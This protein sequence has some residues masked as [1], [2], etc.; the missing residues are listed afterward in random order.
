MVWILLSA[1]VL[2]L[3]TALAL[4]AAR[5]AAK[6]HLRHT[7]AERDKARTTG[8]HQARLQHPHIDLSRCIGCGTCVAACPEEGVLELVHGQAVVVHGARCV[9]H[10]RCA[11]ECPVGAIALTLGDVSD[12]RDL[13]VLRENLESPH[14]PGLFLAGEVT[15][16]A[17]VRTAITQGTAAADQ[18]ARRSRLHA[19][20]AIRRHVQGQAGGG[21]AVAE[22]PEDSRVIDLVI[23][24]AGP[25]GIA[26]SL[27][28]KEL[29][30]AFTTLEQDELGGTV[31]KYPRRK[32]VMTQPVELPLVGRLSRTSYSKE[33]LIEMWQRVARQHELPIQHGQ[34]F[35]RVERL[36]D[37]TLRVHTQTGHVDARSVVLALGRRGTP[38]RLGIPGEELPKVA[39]SLLD[40]HSYQGRRI[41]VVG[42]GDSAVEAA[43]GLAEQPGNQV[44]ISYRKDAF[45]RLKSRNETRVAEA[46]RDG[47][48]TALFGSEVLAIGPD[49]VSLRLRDGTAKA[50]PNDEVFVFAGGTPPTEVLEASGVSLDPR[51]RE[52][53]PQLAEQ[54]T[55]LVPALCVALALAVAVLVWV[56]VHA[57][58]YMASNLDRPHH[59][60]HARLGP[61]GSIGL[62]CGIAAAALV[63]A[64]LS[65]LARRSARFEWIPGSLRAWMTSHVVT[66]IGA[67]LLVLVHGAMAPRSTVGGH[68]AWA[69][70]FLVLTGAIGRYLY[71]FVPRAANGRELELDE[72]RTQLTA[73][74]AE[75]DRGR[76]GYAESL[77]AEVERVVTEER[78]QGSLVNRIHALVT[79][80]RAARKRIA[81]LR[82]SAR[83]EGVATDHIERMSELARR[84]QYT[85]LMAS[86]Y[87][88]LRAI[89]ASWRWFHRWA[90]LFMVLIA[91]WHV[92]LALRY[93]HLG[94]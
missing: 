88:D 35:T 46:L 89:L 1:I 69:M 83:A 64:N 54:G 12:R 6:G 24:G 7:L 72:V 91:G 28:A 37:G 19:A 61:T 50:V 42:G 31:A 47:S 71:S 10:G 45:F 59:P 70:A 16:Y 23:V 40:A 44:A 2:G 3:A 41:L 22:L 82:A 62:T 56:V 58:Y 65:Y 14:V 11:A 48:L 77:R 55:G 49:S 39:Y 60:D 93:A 52:E 67:L 85:A 34:Q 73:L 43:V 5:R 78:W 63:L 21:V 80:Q 17:L 86:H 27:R 36:E 32:L 84:A 53:A 76:G 79:S 87:E 4:T 92:F 9:G 15:G 74:S 68:A 51:Q 94:S 18:A 90:A 25:A 81:A 26:C 75:W 30:L 66:G 57:D 38:R 29:G 8:S 13:P 20:P 33:E